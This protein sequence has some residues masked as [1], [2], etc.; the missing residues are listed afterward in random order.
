MNILAIETTGPACGAALVCH[1]RIIA[2]FSINN[3]MTH[4][5]VLM[6]LVA[7]MLRA[8]DFDKALVDLIACSVGPGSFTGLRI[9]AAAAKGLAFGL[10][11]KIVPVA[12]LDALAYNEHNAKVVVPIM[13]ARRGQVYT[14]LYVDGARV[15]DYLACDID[16]VLE[17]A[18][19]YGKAVFLGDGVAVHRDKIIERGFEV[20]AFQN[21]FQKASSVGA[22]AMKMAEAAVAPRDFAPFYVRQSQ[23]ERE[24]AN[25]GGTL[26]PDVRD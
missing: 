14:A 23:A 2:E 15:T 8:A 3:R 4:S 21:M 9:G 26:P 20:A 13:D 16:D 7:E 11:K 18:A 10:D 1:D 25:R 5:Q 19:P 24:A 17:A 22:L 12:T 6:P